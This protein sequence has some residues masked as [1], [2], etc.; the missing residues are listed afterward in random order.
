MQ[1][2]DT[3]ESLKKQGNEYFA[4]G[5]YDKA[6]EC[7]TLS[8]SKNETPAVFNN[9]AFAL[10]KLDKPPI[11]AYWDAVRVLDLE[12]Y[13]VK[14]H[15]RKN[16]AFQKM[17]LPLT[18]L[19]NLRNGP[20]LGLGSPDIDQL[21]KE[22]VGK[23]PKDVAVYTM[24]TFSTAKK[25][26]VFAVI[27]KDVEHNGMLEM[28]T[29]GNWREM[30]QY[31][32]DRK[33][34]FSSMYLEDVTFNKHAMEF[35]RTV[36]SAA[37]NGLSLIMMNSDMSK[38]TD[39][40]FNELFGERLCPGILTLSNV[41]GITANKLFSSM[42]SL[43]AFRL[44]IDIKLFQRNQREVNQI[45]DVDQFVDHFH[46]NVSAEN[47]KV[48]VVDYTYFSVDLYDVVDRLYNRFVKDSTTASYHLVLVQPKLLPA[49]FPKYERNVFNATTKE[50]FTVRVVRM[51][52]I[53][54][55]CVEAKLNGECR[56]RR[57]R[58]VDANEFYGLDVRR[59]L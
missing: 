52:G 9:R 53:L 48:V 28:K 1:S 17:N 21:E 32:R 41:A 55:E 37:F 30:T 23:I 3:A 13:N 15:Y 36:G 14:A 24:K 35:F 2:E 54:I 42:N 33:V 40:M 19:D 22:F 46:G 20:A 29:F 47:P 18:A 4:E 31:F 58:Q 12:P 6:V 59:G 34:V 38:L 50:R 25:E 27:Q 8:L 10:L 16:L 5:D 56:G 51:G 45:F 57:S 26:V 7:Y 44:S 49:P 39:E 11:Y 43:D